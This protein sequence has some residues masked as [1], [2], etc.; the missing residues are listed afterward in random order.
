VGG[1]TLQNGI[2]KLIVRFINDIVPGNNQVFIPGRNDGTDRRQGFSTEGGRRTSSKR[3]RSRLYYTLSA[4]NV[5][6]SS[7]SKQKVFKSHRLTSIIAKILLS[8]CGRPLLIKNSSVGRCFSVKKKVYSDHSDDYYRGK[9]R[10]PLRVCKRKVKLIHVL[11]LDFPSSGAGRSSRVFVRRRRRHA[12]TNE[13][14]TGSVS[15][16]TERRVM[17][18]FEFLL[19]RIQET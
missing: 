3:Y 19:I 14:F 10:R 15:D 1:R 8:R 7:V 16:P 2:N 9:A 6:P 12:T 4:S 18:L 13:K 11:S 5:T 17:L